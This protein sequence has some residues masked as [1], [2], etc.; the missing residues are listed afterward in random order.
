MR[1]CLLSMTWESIMT[2]TGDPLIIVC[3]RTMGLSWR[4]VKMTLRR[5]PPRHTATRNTT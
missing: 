2:R 1:T 3:T 4:A 5:R